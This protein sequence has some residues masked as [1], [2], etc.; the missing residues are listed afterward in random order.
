MSKKAAIVLLCVLAGIL[1][2]LAAVNL[3][4]E[5]PEVK[6][7]GDSKALVG[8][9][10][11]QVEVRRKG[12]KRWEPARLNQLLCEG[13]EIRTGLFSEATLQVRGESSV[14]VSP[15]TSFELGKDHIK[16]SNFQLGVGQITAAI[17]RTT[18]RQY[19]F[20]SK[21]SDAVAQAEKGEFR[22]SSDGKG[23]V[24]LDTREGKVKLKAKGKEVVV[25]KG[26]RSVVKPDEPPSRVLPIPASVALQV[27]W[28]PSKLDRTKTTVSGKTSAGSLVLVNGILVRA[29][30]LGRFALDVPLREGSNRLVVN[31]TDNAGNTARRES[32]E[33]KV[34]TRPPDINVDAKDLWK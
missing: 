33:I 23:T 4:V 21:G 31:V 29:D 6:E 34:D 17:P 19:S 10:V 18:E 24:I 20:R 2:V 15:N 25:R 28:P 22:L 13:D 1:A 26:R 14:V 3:L 9:L 32:G 5:P 16:Q 11:G 8:S 12:V 27:K 7:A 30:P